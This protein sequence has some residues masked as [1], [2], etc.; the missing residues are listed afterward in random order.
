MTS[1]SVGVKE[2][3]R[4]CDLYQWAT[5]DLVCIAHDIGEWRELPIDLPAK[6]QLKA[7]ARNSREL[8][9]RPFSGIRPVVGIA[10]PPS[11]AALKQL[12]KE[13]RIPE[14]INAQEIRKAIGPIPRIAAG[15]EF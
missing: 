13:I 11:L 4:D 12:A 15:Q 14:F 7:R 2:P 3:M 10:P 6:L 8:S 1:R 5:G 9:L